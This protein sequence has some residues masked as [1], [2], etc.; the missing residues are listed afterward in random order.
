MGVGALG[1]ASMQIA[2]MKYSAGSQTRTQASLLASDMM[3][4]IRANRETALGTALYNTQGFESSENVPTTDCYVSVCNGANTV[5][6]DKWAWL[7][8]V[9]TLLPGGQAQISFQ[10]V[11]GQRMYLIALRWRFV[12]NEQ[13]GDPDDEFQQFLFRAII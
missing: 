5:A 6:Y 9:A 3:D 11:N 7:T 1:V 4:R 8:Q 13:D 2:G 10:D 12:A